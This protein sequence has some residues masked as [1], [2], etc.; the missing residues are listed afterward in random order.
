MLNLI[1]NIFTSGLPV[2]LMAIGILLTFRI[3]D[4]A[5]MTAEG[6]F[7]IGAAISAVLISNHVNPFLATFISFLGGGVCG[8]ITG[9]LNRYLKI[10]KLLSGIITMT[11]AAGLVFLVFGWDKELNQ[12]NTFSLIDPKT[13]TIFTPFRFG[14]A[15]SGDLAS[16]V[17]M[18]GIVLIIMLT[19]YFFFGTEYGMAIRATGMNER[20]A[21]AQGINTNR[22]T[23]TCVAISNAIIGLAGSLFA[24]QGHRIM[25]SVESGFL[26]IGLAAVLIGEAIFGKR[27]FKNVLISVTLGAIVYYVIITFTMKIGTEQYQRVMDILRKAVYAVL[28][29][30]AVSISS[31]KEFI[32]KRKIKK[33]IEHNTKT[34]EVID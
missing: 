19:V 26:V 11:A 33:E 5:D 4:F 3:L 9:I 6:S 31:V 20:M 8:M 28:I 10:P 7:L 32:A 18:V 25:V 22:T 29:T 24:Q 27:S 23:I 21:R 2:C 1:I 17:V 15:L 30:I 16:I 34:S 14:G 12:F 13:P